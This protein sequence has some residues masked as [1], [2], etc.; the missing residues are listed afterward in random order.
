MSRRT[1][2]LYSS[3]DMFIDEL[4]Q[5]LN[6]VALCLIPQIPVM[7]ITEVVHPEVPVRLATALLEVAFF[8]VV[9]YVTH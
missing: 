2:S 9:N 7:F 4:V 5:V 6:I 1:R 8:L 3:S